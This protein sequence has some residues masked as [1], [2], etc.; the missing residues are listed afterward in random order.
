MQ[1]KP[2][3]YIFRPVGEVW[4]NVTGDSGTLADFLTELGILI[5]DKTE[6]ARIRNY[7]ANKYIIYRA[8]AMKVIIEIWDMI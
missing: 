2:K 6:F 3:K 8:C 7:E 4:Q 1:S 5:D